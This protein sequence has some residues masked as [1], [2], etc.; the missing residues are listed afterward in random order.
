VVQQ[1]AAVRSSLRTTIHAQ[2]VAIA[3]TKPAQPQQQ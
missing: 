1:L 2:T 3:T